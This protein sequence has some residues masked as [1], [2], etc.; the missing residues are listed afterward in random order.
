MRP[1]GHLEEDELEDLRYLLLGRGDVAHQGDLDDGH[2]DEH[3]EVA[4]KEDDCADDH[5]REVGL[6]PLLVGLAHLGLQVRRRPD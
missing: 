5:H 3:D 2:G 4:D 6:E 1:H